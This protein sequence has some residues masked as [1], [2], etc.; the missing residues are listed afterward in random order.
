MKRNSCIYPFLCLILLWLSG[1][2]QQ[3]EGKASLSAP[4]VKPQ[5]LSAWA[6]Y[7]DTDNVLEEIASYGER[8]ESL[9][10]FAAYFDAD[11]RVFVPTETSRLR[12]ETKEVYGES[13]DWHSYLSFVNDKL[14]EGG[15]SSLKDTEL[16]YGLLSEES[17][18]KAHIAEII[19]L[20]E[21][22][23]YEGIEI[24]YE[25]IR[26][27]MELWG[28]FIQ[29]IRELSTEAAERG[30]L[31]RVVLEPGIPYGEL[32]FPQGPDYVIMCYNLYGPGSQPGP[33]ADDR[34]LQDLVKKTAGLP[35]RRIF[36]IATGGFDWA[37][38]QVTAL[39]KQDARN[40][41]QQCGATEQRDQGSQALHF[42]YQK[43]NIPHQV[44][45]ADNATLNHW[46][47]LLWDA[48]DFDVAIWRLSN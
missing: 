19:A 32:S 41:A 8:L 25:A 20:T 23:D 35:G 37:G 7:W 13:P 38:E 26:K 39:S 9:Q 16:L 14:L 29:F 44:W 45:Y 5:K 46:I 3:G 4:S 10:Y 11:G 2:G 42:S 27:D 34:F 6:A 40:L 31:L 24:D 18:R 28:Y 30:L 1:C 17:A 43:D 12:E 48:G 47:T 22:G 36:A 15:G 21:A 33:K